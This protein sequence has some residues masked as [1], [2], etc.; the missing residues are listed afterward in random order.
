MHGA[1]VKVIMYKCLSVVIDG[2]L[3]VILHVLKNVGSN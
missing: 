3:L 1:T 2:A